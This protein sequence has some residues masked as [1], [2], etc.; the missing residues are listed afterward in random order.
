VG[1]TPA[2]TDS[3]NEQLL[4]WPSEPEPEAIALIHKVD[5]AAGRAAVCAARRGVE[6]I[7]M[8]SAITCPGV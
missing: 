6:C 3:S 5:L 4:T 8:L 7:S 2:A 1:H